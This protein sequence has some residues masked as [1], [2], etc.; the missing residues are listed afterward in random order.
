[1]LGTL[2]ASG[3][4]SKITEPVRRMRKLFLL[5]VFFHAA[6][7]VAAA[8]FYVDSIH[9]RIT[10][11]ISPYTVEV[12]S[13]LPNNY[14]YSGEVVIPETVTYDGI[15]Y[16]VTAIGIC[17]FAGARELTSV[18]IPGTV[19]AID[20]M[21]FINCTGLKTVAL[22][23]SVRT[24]GADAFSGCWGLERLCIGDA[25]TKIGS[26]AFSYAKS[27]THITVS[28]KNKH[29]KVVD[30]V[31]YSAKLDTLVLCPASREGAFVIPQK[32]SV[33]GLS[34]F[35]GCEKLTGIC[36]HD[37]LLSI[38]DSAFM[39]CISLTE[40]Q[41]PKSVRKIG[42]CSFGLCTSLVNFVMDGKNKRYTADN[43]VLYTKLKDT[44]VAYPIGRNDTAYIFPHTVRVVGNNAFLY[45]KITSVALPNSVTTV[46]DNAFRSCSALVN[47]SLGQS[48]KV[49]G[50]SAFM[51]CEKMKMLVLPNTLNVIGER[52]FGRCKS[53]SD[54]TIGDSVKVIGESAFSYCTNL[55]SVTLGEAVETV[56]DM[57]FCGSC[58]KLARL[59]FRG[60]KRPAVGLMAFYMP[61]DSDAVTVPLG[62]GK[63]NKYVPNAV[64]TQ[65]VV[66]CGKAQEYTEYLLKWF[67]D[68]QENCE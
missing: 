54:I 10:S 14:K 13:P 23:N 48:L 61:P 53:L 45:S 32:T 6:T 12:A 4:R 16:K 44:L 26:C 21:A 33:V 1:M 50:Q 39:G 52:G 42:N 36:F 56:G 17:S 38:G 3:E 9:Y 64:V 66:P 46:G 22:P 7:I 25:L 59:E 31:L 58:G 11:G 30:N 55:V 40:V 43:G 47:V 34:A 19:V 49:V 65:V 37:K 63:D 28:G 8:D 29:F 67:D 15:A 24:I 20:P 27:L 62:S 60:P 68:I 51:F 41:I 35:S 57:A 2:R 5:A 18:S